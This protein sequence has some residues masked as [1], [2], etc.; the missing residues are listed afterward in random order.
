MPTLFACAVGG[1]VLVVAVGLQAPALSVGLRWKWTMR[2]SSLPP[3]DIE[4]FDGG[5]AELAGVGE[6][7]LWWS[8][9]LAWILGALVASGI[10][11]WVMRWIRRHTR[12]SPAI[13]LTGM[14]ADGGV[15][16]EPDAQIVHSG[17]AAALQT[18]TSGR[19]P[20]NAVVQ[21][22][23]GL[24]DAA[25]A[26]GLNRRSAETTSEFTARILYRSRNSAAPIDVLQSLYQ[27]VRF[28]DHSPDAGEIASAR[29]SLSALIELWQTDLPDRRPTERPR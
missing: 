28:G 10:L 2:S 1:F 4:P 23:Q 3:I 27:R 7:D 26:A 20:G 17:L 24:Q 6:R 18:L 29:D 8:S 14:G 11:I 16:R 13:T 12:P 9:T 5:V 22:W 15:P 25:A 21:A 19:D